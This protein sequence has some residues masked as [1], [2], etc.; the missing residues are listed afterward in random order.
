MKEL[1]EFTVWE[2]GVGVSHPHKVKC[3]PAVMLFYSY[4]HFHGE[5]SVAKV[6]RIFL[7]FFLRCDR[8][9]GRYNACPPT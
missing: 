2:V 5:L 3:L 8:A 1:N 9:G 4:S 7:L 6:P